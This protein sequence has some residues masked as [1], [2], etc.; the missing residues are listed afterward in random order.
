MPPPSCQKALGHPAELL[1]STTNTLSP[2]RMMANLP[3]SLLVALGIIA[4][5]PSIVY[6]QSPNDPYYYWLS[7]GR[8]AGIAVGPSSS[9]SHCLND[10][11]QVLTMFIQ[12]PSR[13]S[14]SSWS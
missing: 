1:R 7:P 9:T 4:I 6:A 12:V 11:F 14:F 13:S 8:I 2:L 5:Q 10:A 3:A